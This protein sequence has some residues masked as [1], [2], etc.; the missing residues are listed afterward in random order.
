MIAAIIILST[1]LLIAIVIILIQYNSEEEIENRIERAKSIQLNQLI[2]RQCRYED[3]CY[4][5][6][7][8]A[9]KSEGTDEEVK[10]KLLQALLENDVNRAEAKRLKNII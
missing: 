1:L 4:K 2:I 6:V 10:A 5:R 3:A 7:L 8:T 9:L